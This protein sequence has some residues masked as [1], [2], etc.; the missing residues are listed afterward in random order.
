MRINKYIASSGFCSRRK[1]EEYINNNR[2]KVN[3]EV[4]GLS[5][6][7]NEN[8][9]VTIDDKKIELEKNYIY[10]MLNKPQ[11]HLS[12]VSDDRGRKTVVDIIKDKYNERIFPIGRLDFDT[13]GLILL[14]NDGDF[15]NRVIHPKFDMY[16]TYEVI[17]DKVIDDYA[18]NKISKSVEI[19]GYIIK[20][21]II[22]RDKSNKKKFIVKIKEGKNRQIK[23]MFLALNAK[24]IYLK[25]TAI[26][27]LK[28]GNLKIGEFR[29][30]TEEEKNLF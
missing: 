26:G 6:I 21:S 9:T 11:N 25:R 15:S 10:L 22:K 16:K 1:A 27:D 17:I 20:N 4:V 8:D 28:L 13:E 29:E 23:K 24:V 2:V 18:V 19:D 12:S 5:Y 3:G 30:L 14:T 7:V